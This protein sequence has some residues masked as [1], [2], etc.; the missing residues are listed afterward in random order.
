MLQLPPCQS[1]QILGSNPL[2]RHVRQE[3]SGTI[4][5]HDEHAK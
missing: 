4:A 5:K 2:E 3:A 1:V